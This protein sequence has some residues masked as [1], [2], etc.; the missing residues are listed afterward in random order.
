MP[1]AG[2][3]RQDAASGSAGPKRQAETRGVAQLEVAFLLGTFLWRSKEK[4]RARGAR[5]AINLFKQVDHTP[6]TLNK[7]ISQ[8]KI[9]QTKPPVYDGRRVVE[10]LP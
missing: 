5:T 1:L 2:P 8:N 9:E 4:Y 6:N 10:N 3:S 7:N